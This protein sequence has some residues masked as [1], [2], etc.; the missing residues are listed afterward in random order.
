M[1]DKAKSMDSLA[2]MTAEFQQ[3]GGE[4]RKYPETV[5]EYTRRLKEIRPDVSEPQMAMLIHHVKAHPE[6]L[7]M[8]EV[9]AAAGQVTFGFANI[10]YGGLG[11]LLTKALAIPCPKWQVHTLASFDEHPDERRRRGLIHPPLL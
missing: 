3:N 8:K 7:T 1:Q 6:A 4:I 11:A 5:D 9:A 10:H 2:Q